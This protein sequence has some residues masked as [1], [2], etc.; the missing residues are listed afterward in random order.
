MLCP[1]E[2]EAS[3]EDKIYRNIRFLKGTYYINDNMLHCQIFF[4]QSKGLKKQQW[5]GGT[6][7]HNNCGRLLF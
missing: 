3:S 6:I 5:S 4:Q 1:R 2:C 7:Q